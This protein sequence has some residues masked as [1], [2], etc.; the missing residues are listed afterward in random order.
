MGLYYRHEPRIIAPTFYWARANYEGKEAIRAEAPISTRVYTV[1][2]IRDWPQTTN[3][4]RNRRKSLFV[5]FVFVNLELFTNVRE[6]NMQTVTYI[7]HEI[8]RICVLHLFVNRKILYE[9]IP[10]R[11]PLKLANFVQFGS[12][13]WIQCVDRVIDPARYWL[14]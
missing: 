8:S 6:G 12:H 13:V 14:W 3:T 5:S 2:T 4:N 9:F 1:N 7:W 11:V 10:V